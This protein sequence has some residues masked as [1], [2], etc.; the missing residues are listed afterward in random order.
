MVMVENTRVTR[1]R[2]RCNKNGLMSL[3]TP[4][5]KSETTIGKFGMGNEFILVGLNGFFNFEMTKKPE[6]QT[7]PFHCMNTT[8][9]QN[10]RKN[11]AL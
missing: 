5:E 2:N 6:K 10:S 3:K 1:M 9:Q 11:P 8:G 7:E 4:W